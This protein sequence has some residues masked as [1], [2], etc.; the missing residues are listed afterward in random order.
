VHAAQRLDPQGEG[1]DVQQQHVLHLAGQHARLD[2]G[3]HGH[4]LVGIDAPV[5]LLSEN[6]AYLLLDARHPGH[7]AHEDHLVD[8]LGGKPGVLEGRLAG[9]HEL[10][11]ELLHQRLELG[12]GELHEEVFGTGGISRD[13]GQVDVRLHG[14]RELHLRLFCGFLDSLQGHAVLAEIDPLLLLEL[15]ADVIHQALVKVFAAQMGVAVGGFHLED[16]LAQLQDGDVEGPPAQVEDGDLLVLLLVETV[17]ERGRRRLVDD[18]QD[19]QTGDLAGVLRGLALRVVEVGGNGDDGVGHLLPQVI[20]GGLFHLH[21]DEGRYFRR[22][23]AAVPDGDLGI[24]V[25]GFSDLEGNDSLVVL[26]FPGGELPADEPL[27]GVD[28]ILGVGDGLPLGGLTH[29][30][31]PLVGE[32]H[33]RRRRPAAFLVRDDG[34]VTAFHDG[35]AG[36]RRAQIDSD[37]FSHDAQT[38][39]T[40]RSAGLLPL[41]VP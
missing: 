18:A 17:G 12:P 13:E 2:G 34:G 39:C 36:V 19:V 6:F 25:G 15:V 32:G 8:L 40:A 1:R 5:G 38:S 28:G 11:D 4:D 37:H 7:A 14:R 3:A 9:G 24:A 35:H 20:L 10:L 26:N 27:D 41:R 31:L 21:E 16:A 22:A 23:V 29:E 33:H 30:P